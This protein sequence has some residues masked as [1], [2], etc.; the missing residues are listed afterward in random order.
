[1]SMLAVGTA[2]L[3]F[4]GSISKG[5]A[6][7]DTTETER[8]RTLRAHRAPSPPSIDGRLNETAWTG[9]SVAQGFRQLRPNE[10]KEASQRTEVRILY[11][12]DALYVGATMY[13][14]RPERIQDRLTRRDQL[15]QA[16]WF[17]VSIDSYFDRQTAR[18]FAVNA[19]GVQRDGVVRGGG[20]NPVTASWDGIWRSAVRQT[21]QGWIAELRIPYDML[22]FSSVERQTWGI[23]F[24]R[25]IPRTGEVLEWPLVPSAERGASLVAGYGRL[26]ELRDLNPDR[27][28][29]VT[30]YTLGRLRSQEQSEDPVRTNLR[31]TVDVGGHFEVGVGAAGAT[32]QGTINPDF[33]QVESDPSVLNLTAFETFFDEKRPFFL[34]GTDVFDFSL[35]FR[36]ELLYTRRIGANAPVIGALKLT[37]RSDQDL[38]YGGMV[39]TTGRDFEPGRYYGVGH[40]QKQVGPISTVGGMVTAYSG[41]LS[42]R[43]G[44]RRSLAGGLNWDLRF[45]DNTGQVNGYVSGTHRRGT[46]SPIAGVA[47]NAEV[48][49]V[50]SNWNFNVGFRLRDDDFDPNDL[51]RL[52]ANNFFRVSSFH[53]YQFNGGQPVG[54]FRSLSGNF[55][56]DHSWSYQTRRSLGLFT[57]QKIDA[58]TENFRPVGLRLE[59]DYVFGGVDQ[60]ETRGLWPRARP[61]RGTGT[62]SLGT[63]TRRAW[64][65]TANLSGTART[66]G[67]RAWS[68]GLD[69]EWNVASR[70]KL[71][72]SLSYRQELGVVEWAANET[73]V[74][75]GP[76]Q[77]AIGSESASPSAL[78]PDALRPLGRGTDQLAAALSGVSTAGT[79][80]GGQPTYYAPVYG[81]RDTERLNLTLRSNVALTKDLSFE[82]FGQ[83]FGARGRYRDFQILSDRDDLNSFDAYPKRHDFARSS[84]I[85]NAVLRWEFRPGSE[86]FVVWSQDRRL[87][88]TEPFFRDRRSSSPYNRPAGRRLTDAFRDVP[89]NAFIVKLRYTI[90]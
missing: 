42:D 90:R 89:R 86:L 65:L 47:M 4:L 37:G 75:R 81:R 35:G 27:R 72:G 40:L 29:Q 59:G 18:T 56:V 43:T 55:N 50:R 60:F 61:A 45:A 49:R 36:S 2:L 74:R 21:A 63:D 44:R 14:E 10:G 51:G 8:P 31:S 33:G 77:W 53:T 30:P 25:R 6:P 46:G 32:L 7:P 41:P 26:T 16:D 68:A 28:L 19:A 71:S 9:A 70:L 67:G 34:D 15:N 38:L 13:D 83:L 88:R 11:G 23:Q 84:F 1:M 82:F 3:A 20:A 24:R 85:A 76:D 62:L 22:R 78:G 5:A 87:R 64:Q 52:R 39:A 69:A 79:S 54:P 57:F 17:S 73:F 12:R 80:I 58:L 66:D 48:G